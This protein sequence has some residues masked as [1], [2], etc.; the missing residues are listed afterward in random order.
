MVHLAI[1]SLTIGWPGAHR[2]WNRSESTALVSALA[3]AWLVC[4]LLIATFV[5]QEWLNAWF[6]TALWTGVVLVS[7]STA[8]KNL[9]LGE[10][11][12]QDSRKLRDENLVLAQSAYLQA[13]YFE[14][15]KYLVENLA[16][17]PADIESALLLISVLRRTSRWDQA[18]DAIQQLQRRDL[19]TRWASEIAV[20]KERCLRGKRQ[21]KPLPPPPL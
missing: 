11:P 1:R 2:T 13:S 16:K 20:E 12:E 7:L 19:A 3:F 10:I 4:L 15:E 14:A 6:V 5:W 17:Q 21:T 9:W 18:L 8:A